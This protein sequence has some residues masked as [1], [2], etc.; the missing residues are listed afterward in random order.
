MLSNYVTFSVS[1]YYAGKTVFMG[2]E[3]LNILSLLDPMVL[4]E[5]HINF[6]DN[7]KIN[8]VMNAVLQ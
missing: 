2:T 3:I 8:T 4:T 7:T 5:S 1:L 6:I